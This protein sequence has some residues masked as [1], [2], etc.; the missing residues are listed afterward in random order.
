MTAEKEL[1]ALKI[2]YKNLKDKYDVVVKKNGELIK[3]DTPK[4]IK[5]WREKEEG[6][7]LQTV[8]IE[9]PKCEYSFS[10]DEI[11]REISYCP[12]CG[13]CLDWNDDE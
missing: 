7:D 2:D 8:Y 10:D 12:E 9:C 5:W 13:Q 1:E 6:F 4:K 11:E 3:R